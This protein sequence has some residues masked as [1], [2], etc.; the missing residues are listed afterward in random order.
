MFHIN[1]TTDNAAF[2]DDYFGEAA[3]ILKD[4]IDSMEHGNQDGTIHDSNGN[5]IGKW[6][7]H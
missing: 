7:A 3:Q 2:T 4:V 5:T 1:F 6:S